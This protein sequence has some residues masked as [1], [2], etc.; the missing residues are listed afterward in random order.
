MVLT[1]NDLAA[2]H[3]ASGV[4]KHRKCHLRRQIHQDD[5]GCPLRDVVHHSRYRG[6]SGQHFNAFDQA[7]HRFQAGGQNGLVAIK[8]NSRHNRRPF[9]RG[10]NT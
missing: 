2:P 10:V 4:A 3:S 6:T 9:S 5:I 8:K 7:Q 1:K